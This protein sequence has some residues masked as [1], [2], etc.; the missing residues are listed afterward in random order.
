[1][2]RDGDAIENALRHQLQQLVLVADVPVEGCGFHTE[3]IGE[4]A[5][6]EPVNA[7]GVEHPQRGQND[8]FAVQPCLLLL[9]GHGRILPCAGGSKDTAS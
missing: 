4:R 7:D 1:M 6:G 9:T 3:T 8:G 5:H 2:R